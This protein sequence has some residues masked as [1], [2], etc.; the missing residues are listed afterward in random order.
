MVNNGQKIVKMLAFFPFD[1]TEVNFKNCNVEIGF[2]YN[3]SHMYYV[4]ISLVQ[5]FSM[6]NK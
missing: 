5:S 2:A 6:Q 1:V 4:V 3:D